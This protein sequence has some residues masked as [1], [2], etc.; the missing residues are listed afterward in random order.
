MLQ[1]QIPYVPSY[2]KDQVALVVMEDSSL[3]QEM[4]GYTR[5]TNDQ[6]SNPGNEGVR[7]GECSGGLVE[8]PTHV[9]VC[10]LHGPTEPEGLRHDYAH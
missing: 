10:Q 8:H 1:V 3:P 9:R 6:P 5:N 2:D 4:P 7:D